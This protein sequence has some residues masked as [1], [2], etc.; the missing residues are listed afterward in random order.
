ML[1]IELAFISCA[2]RMSV[3]FPHWR[4]EIGEFPRRESTDRSEFRQS[5]DGTARC[6]ELLESGDRRRWKESWHRTR[7][8]L[9]VGQI[10]VC[11]R[12]V[13]G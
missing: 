13:R 11:V 5:Q 3:E 10:A 9:V 7:R 6:T 2:A 8:S 4:R 12:P 1:T